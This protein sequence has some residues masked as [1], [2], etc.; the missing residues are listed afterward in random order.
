MKVN[1]MNGM[2]LLGMA[3]NKTGTAANKTGT[4]AQLG[5]A[6]NKTGTAAQLGT[7]ALIA[8]MMQTIRLATKMLQ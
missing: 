2:M 5:T 3:V 6:A 7:A 4:A 1:Q 8:E